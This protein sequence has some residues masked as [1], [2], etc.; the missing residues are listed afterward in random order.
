MQPKPRANNR[1]LVLCT[2]I[3][4]VTAWPFWKFLQMK[5]V[6]GVTDMA[7]LAFN[8]EGG[9]FE[10]RIDGEKYTLKNYAKVRG[11]HQD[12]L[13]RFLH[14]WHDPGRSYFVYGGHGMGDYLEL[15]QEKTSLQVHELAQIFGRRRFE[16]ILFDAC[17]MSNLDCAYHLRDNTRYIGACEGYMWEPDTALDYHVFNT[18]NASVM[19]R[20][21]DPKHILEAIQKEYVSKA[22]RGDFAVL[23][24]THTAALRQFVQDHVIQR[25]YNR[26]M[27]YS[28]AQQERVSQLAQAAITTSEQQY[29]EPGGESYLKNLETRRPCSSPTAP[30][31]RLRASV[32]RLKS[33]QKMMQAIQF[34]H[35]LYPSESLDKHL[36]DLRSYLV[37]MAIEEAAV[38]EGRQRAPRRRAAAG[39]YTPSRAATV[40][41]HASYPADS[42][43]PPLSPHILSLHHASDDEPRTSQKHRLSGAS[44]ASGAISIFSPDSAHYGLDLFQKVVLSHAAPRAASIYASRLGG[45]SVAVHEFSAMS[46]PLNPWLRMSKTVLKKKAK[47]FLRRG[48]LEEV[49]GSTN[50]PTLRMPTAPTTLLPQQPA[51]ACP[52]SLGSP[53]GTISSTTQPQ[54]SNQ[55]QVAR[56]SVGNH[57]A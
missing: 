35:A 33:Q 30:D 22:P 11:Y 50:A 25:V 26:A 6:K 13:E 15:E 27:F 28:P 17:F 38:R 20:Y 2:S 16:A 31:A 4:D 7:L 1:L 44:S 36:I 43:Q 32:G 55:R 19:S 24:T 37:D 42:P 48:Y 53:M 54:N 51:S 8:T 18:H 56:V 21:K 12:M 47:A 14:R 49:K 23:D 29:G 52:Q 5:K 40:E 10:A 39:A 34:E 45:L 41:A 3:N 46:K 57:K 9:S